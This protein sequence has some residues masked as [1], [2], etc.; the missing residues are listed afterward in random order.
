MYAKD[1]LGA[2]SIFQGNFINFGYWKG[3][4]LEKTITLEERQN[5]LNQTI[6]DLKQNTETLFF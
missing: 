2:E 1:D 4:N 5:Q 6:N 3:C